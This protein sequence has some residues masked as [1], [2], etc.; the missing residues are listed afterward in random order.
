MEGLASNCDGLNVV[1]ACTNL[2]QA[3]PDCIFWHSNALRTDELVVLDRSLDHTVLEQGGGGVVLERRQSQNQ[4]RSFE[5]AYK[6]S[7]KTS[8]QLLVLC[9]QSSSPP[10]LAIASSSKSSG[11]SL[12]KNSTWPQ[13]GQT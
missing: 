2:L 8:S 11:L 5:S 7:M 13:L 1:P 3:E 6:C 4:H 9:S 10:S 12:A